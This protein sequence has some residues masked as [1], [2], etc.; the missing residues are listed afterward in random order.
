VAIT[1]EAPDT[2]HAGEVITGTV[3]ASGH[4]RVFVRRSATWRLDAPIHEEM[5]SVVV[6]GDAPFTLP[7]VRGP[8]TYRGESIKLDWSIVAEADGGDRAEAP[9][10]LVAPHATTYEREAAGGYRDRPTETTTLEPD[11][12]ARHVEGPRPVGAYIAFAIFGA[13]VA[14]TFA[15]IT[16]GGGATNVTLEVTPLRVRVGGELTAKLAFATREELV[17][18]SITFELAAREHFRLARRETEPLFE[19]HVET[20]TERA[21]LAPG[22]HTYE[23]RLHVK[24]G[25]P[26]SFAL[27]HV[28]VEW[29]VRA[30]LQIDGRV[31]EVREIVIGVAPF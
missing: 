19:S 15:A 4:T 18:E 27:A 24:E 11:F 14:R 5:Q 17:V 22:A 26:A 1:L 30:T 25:A 12:G 23:S 6:D 31:D 7:A 9:F 8:L 13:W 29:F 10:V 16:G 2:V 3:R 20:I 28:A 21:R